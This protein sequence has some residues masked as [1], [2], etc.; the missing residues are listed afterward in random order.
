MG[1]RQVPGVG[2]KCLTKKDKDKVKRMMIV[3]KVETFFFAP[4]FVSFF[5]A[6]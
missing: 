3:G 6:M 1:T 4:V 5:V 2:Q